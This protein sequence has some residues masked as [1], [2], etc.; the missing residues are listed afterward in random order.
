MLSYLCIVRDCERALYKNG[1]I[2]GTIKVTAG[3][4]SPVAFCRTGVR[5]VDISMNDLRNL[6]K[7]LESLS[8]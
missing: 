2:T 7:F 5:Y 6:K 3:K 1:R 4:E 8:G